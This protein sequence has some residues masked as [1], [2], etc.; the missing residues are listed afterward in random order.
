MG[1]AAATATSA[2]RDFLGNGGSGGDA[3]SGNSGGE[4]VAVMAT[5]TVAA[6]TSF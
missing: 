3:M 4:E 2:E 1:T 5:A 6:G